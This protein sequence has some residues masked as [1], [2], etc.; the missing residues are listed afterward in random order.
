MVGVVDMAKGTRRIQRLPDPLQ[1]KAGLVASGVQQALKAD[2][3][4]LVRQLF[5]SLR[6]SLPGQ[7]QVSVEEGTLRGIIATIYVSRCFSEPDLRCLLR[8]REVPAVEIDKLEVKG[9]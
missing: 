7:L 9:P 2:G 6:Q 3:H 1:R 8:A 4:R 5:Q